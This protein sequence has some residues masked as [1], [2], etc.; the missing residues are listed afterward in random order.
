MTERRLRWALIGVTMFAA[1]CVLAVAAVLWYW[2]AYLLGPSGEVFTRGPYLVHV[3]EQ[4]ATLKW[5]AKD[6]ARGELVAPPPGGPF[7]TPPARPVPRPQ[8]G[9]PHSRAAAVGG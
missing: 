2:H 6:A 8:P 7:P 1:L 9:T 3:D 4:G 5:R